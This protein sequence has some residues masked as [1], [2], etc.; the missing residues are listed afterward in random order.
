LKWAGKNKK[1]NQIVVGFALEDKAVRA[2]AEKKLR[3]KNLDMIIANTP[4]AI[5]TDKSTVHIRTQDSR[6]T[7]IE[8][9]TKSIIAKKVVSVISARRKYE[10]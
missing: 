3:E 7:K 2:R 5:G 10:R 9:A 4:A 1:K 8:N 6:W